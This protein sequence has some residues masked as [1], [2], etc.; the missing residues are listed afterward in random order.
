M[1]ESKD[2]CE[3]RRVDRSW[4]LWNIGERP[5]RGDF[6]FVEKEGGWE[7]C[8]VLP[9]GEKGCFVRLPVNKAGETPWGADRSPVWGW[10]GNED[11]PTLTP[12]VWTHGYW[13]G[14]IRAGRMESC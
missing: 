6:Q 1:S 12:S 13:H 7:I 10:D 2:S 4:D 11:K 9:A 5:L 14:F 8:M 3:M